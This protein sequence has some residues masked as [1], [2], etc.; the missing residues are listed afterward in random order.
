MFSPGSSGTSPGDR[1]LTGTH[2][3]RATSGTQQ[4][5]TSAAQR[6]DTM[7]RHGRAITLAGAVLLVAGCAVAGASP[8]SAPASTGPAS[9]EST[10]PVDSSATAGAAHQVAR[11]VVAGTAVFDIPAGW[12]S[13]NGAINPGGNW[14]VVFVSP[15]VLPGECTQGA[16]EGVCYAWP[17]TR[18]VPGETVIAWRMYGRPGFQPPPG[19]EPMAI[20]GRPARISYGAAEAAC[21]AIG[22]DESV[23]VVMA[24]R[25][26]ESAWIGIDACQAGPDHRAAEAAFRQLLAS[27]TWQPS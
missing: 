2:S 21:A 8:S 25:P 18:L 17:V 10:G 7:N 15:Q 26:G 6:E 12:H 9:P 14:T 3:L 5:I 22:G 4:A 16:L 19:G 11:H 24:A 1:R 20:G 13:R 27:V 23:A